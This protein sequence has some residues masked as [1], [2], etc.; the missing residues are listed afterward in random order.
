ME[1]DAQQFINEESTAARSDISSLAEIG[2]NRDEVAAQAKSDP[3]FLAAL[4]LGDIFS[5][6]FAS[7]HLSFWEILTRNCLESVEGFFKYAF[8]LPRGHAKTTLLK[9]YLL[10]CILF[11]KKTFFLVVSASTQLA[12][13]FL[14]DVCTYLDH[15]NIVGTFGN[16]RNGLKKDT[17]EL[18]RF[19]FLGRE[20]IL[21]AMGAESSLRGLNLANERPQVIICE[22]IQTKECA[23]SPVLN[24]K[25][26]KWFLGTLLK[27]R[28][29]KW[30]QLVYIGNMYNEQCLLNKLR[31]SSE[32]FSFITSAIL[33]G[34]QALWPEFRSYESLMAEFRN[35]ISLGHPEIFLAEVMNDPLAEATSHFDVSKIPAYKYAD[36]VL[37]DGGFLTVDPALGLPGGNATA[38]AHHEVIDGLDVV[39]KVYTGQWNDEATVAKGLEIAVSERLPLIGVES[40]AYQAS[41]CNYF[42]REIQ[43]KQI[44]GIQIVPI[45]TRGMSKS[46]G[47][48]DYLK[49]LR[50]GENLVH[51]EAQPIVYFQAARYNPTRRDNEDD[52]LDACKMGKYVLN[53][54]WHEVLFQE[55]VFDA[56]FEKAHIQSTL[57]NSPF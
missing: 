55:R 11:T 8:G 46:A 38:I 40:V 49:G 19:T 3:N 52:V 25:F 22:D 44:H 41:L 30:A 2:L 47:I 13:N 50:M 15:P 34:R 16:W 45:K 37:A 12:A 21:A 4:V 23:D 53:E 28:A 32:W 26:I 7:A 54:H 6:D 48:V 56:D 20:V 5:T 10:W 33:A 18:K 9:I 29:P 57:D 51:P 27:A 31:K 24:D 17:E 36:N 14:S 35:D 1:R 39:R 42:V 43:A